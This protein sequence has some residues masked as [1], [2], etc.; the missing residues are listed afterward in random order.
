MIKQLTTE[1]TILAHEWNLSSIAR[2]NRVVGF[3]VTSIAIS[4]MYKCNGS[5]A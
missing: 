2:L 5:Y 4:C 3:H 1:P